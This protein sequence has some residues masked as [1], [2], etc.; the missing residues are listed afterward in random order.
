MSLFAEKVGWKMQRCD[1]KMV[2]D[3]C[4]E[5]GIR[6]GIFKVWMHNNKNTIGRKD[7]ETTSPTTTTPAITSPPST[8]GIINVD[9]NGR[10]VVTNESHEEDV[11]VDGRDNS[12]CSN[13]ENDDGGGGGG[14]GGG[15]VGSCGGTV[16]PQASTNG[17]SSC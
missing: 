14:G 12:N 2:A 8:A 11:N 7:K 9:N 15:G 13:Q 16:H 5:I 4:N 6:R 1:D 10:L 3:F 17:S